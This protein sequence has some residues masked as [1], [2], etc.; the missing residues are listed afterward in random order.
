MITKKTNVLQIYIAFLLVFSLLLVGC[1]NSSS[2]PFASTAAAFEEETVLDYEVYQEESILAQK[3]FHAFTTELFQED[4]TNNQ[5]DMHFLVKDPSSYNLPSAKN[6][7][8]PTSLEQMEEDFVALRAQVNTLSNISVNSLTDEQKLTYRILES[9]FKTELLLEDLELYEQPLAPTIGVQAQ[10]PIL[11]SEYQFYDKQ[12]VEIYLQLLTNIDSYYQTLLT[13]E[14]MI[15]AHD[16]MMS[17]TTIDHVIESCESYLL[18]PGNNFMIDSFQERIFQVPN[19][20]SEEIDNYIAQNAAALEEHFVPAYQLLID[21]LTALKGTGVNDKGLCGFP[22]GT[23]YYEYLVYANTGTSFQSVD[24]M[25]KVME[26]Q[27][28]SDLKQITALTKE[29]PD[30]LNKVNS[31]AFNE[32]E[33]NAILESLKE[34]SL[35]EFPALPECTYALKEVPSTLQHSLSPAFYLTPPIDD[36]QNNI[37]YINTSDRYT[38]Q[39]Y[40]TTLAHE[41]FPGHLYQTVY[42]RASD[43]DPIRQLYANTGFCEGWAIYVE[44]MSYTMGDNGLDPQLGEL[45]GINM[46]ASLGLQAC[47]D[48]YIN[49]QGWDQQQ[50]QEYLSASYSDSEELAEQIYNTMIENPS[51]YLSYYVGYLEI[52]GMRT[53]A[54]EKLG[55]DFDAKEFHTFLLD[56]GAAPFDVIQRYFTTWLLSQQL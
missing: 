27:L 56:M 10:L 42:F 5:L 43:V 16:L 6:L 55:D 33:F 17:D 48:V 7:Y 38:P 40:Y 29:S 36:Y 1:S 37:I 47:L 31:Y 28:E 32:T 41:G 8:S 50:V 39:S 35:E 46:V 18:V 19:L 25:L 49:Y 24:E 23:S 54:E 4:L 22:N 30:L 9:V 53:I 14:Q 15:S 20:T 3:E 51:N 45:L 13:W 26:Q 34:K 2:L 52:M 21:G 44:R 12:D 11:L